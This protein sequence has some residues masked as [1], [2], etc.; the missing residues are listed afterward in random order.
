MHRENMKPRNRRNPPATWPRQLSLEVRRA[1]VL[2]AV[3]ISCSTACLAQEAARS[4]FASIE[5]TV[6]FRKGDG[7]SLLHQARITVES[8]GGSSAASVDVRSPGGVTSTTLGRRDAGLSKHWVDVPDIAQPVQVEFVLRI[9]G[10]EADRRRM[11]WKPRRKWTICW[12]PLAHHDWGYTDS[13]EDVLR[14]YDQIYDSVLEFCD[15][16]RDWPEDSKYRHTVEGSWSI[17]HYITNRPKETIEKLAAYAREG[18]IE[19]PAFYGNEITGM[20]GHEELA[21][22]LYPSFR[23]KRQLGMDIT[24][25]SITDIPGLSWAIPTLL[26]DVNVKY[27]FAGLPTYFQWDNLPVPDFWD[28]SRVLRSHGRPDAFWWEGPD[29]HRVLVYYSG[30]YGC[31]RA[32]SYEEAVE[33]LPKQLDEQ[34]AAGVPFSVVRFGAYG[35][36]DNERPRI[37]DSAI[38]RRWNETWAYPRLVMSTTTM[39]FKALE[40]D[41]EEQG[42]ALRTFRGE[43]PHTD[44]AVGAVSTARETAIN[45]LTHDRLP[46]AEKLAT[47]AAVLAESHVPLARINDAYDD[48]LM[49]DEHTWGMARPAGPVQDWDW[50]DKAHFA[51]RAAGL[52]ETILRQGVERIADR[53]KLDAEGLHLVVFNSLSYPR[54]DVARFPVA[55]WYPIPDYIFQGKFDLVDVE[56]GAKLPFQMVRLDSPQAPVP[57]AAQRYAIGHVTNHHPPSTWRFHHELYDVVF[58][59]TDV[60][61]MGYRTYRV[62][63]RDDAPVPNTSLTLDDTALENRFYRVVLD[64]KTG[65]V[66]SLF[67]KELGKELVDAKAPHKLNQFVARWIKDY[68]QEG[69]ANITIRKGEQGPVYA[70]LRVNGVGA[71]CPELNQEIL[72][73]D[74]VK[75]IDFNNRVLKDSTPHLELY[76]AFPFELDKPRFRF[77]GGNSVIRPFVDQF[78]GSNTNYYSVQH[79]AEASNGGAAVVFA[80]IESHLLEFG[81]LWPCRVSQAHH[82]ITNP[83]F[84]EPFIKPEQ[85]AK[86]YMYSFALMSSF[87]TNFQ[88]TQEGDMLFRYSLTSLAAEPLPS[89]AADSGK[90]IT[91]RPQTFGW[92]VG[93]PLVPFGIGGRRGGTLGAAMGFCTIDQPNVLVT[94]FKP[95]EDSQGYIARLIETE[96]KAVTA[97]VGLPHLTVTKAYR[98]NLGEENAE[99][100]AFG[101]HRVQVSLNPFGIATIRLIVSTGRPGSDVPAGVNPGTSR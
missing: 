16:T 66:A 75:R 95:A 97:G 4:K 82:G 96:G 93:N 29:G 41:I 65:G 22:F 68:R 88:P 59:A 74:Q 73:Y 67:D 70:S 87:R 7:G 72:L 92:A 12:V 42:Q 13:A 33:K 54:S 10:T 14:K 43:L 91:R 9:N 47:M 27:F 53:I 28:A 86:G 15:R 44:Y 79:W 35:C 100:L 81:G 101:P 64:P 46:A 62:L 98:T 6:F 94:T 99:E 37:E 1:A 8:N 49:Y 90:A 32:V 11:E 89:P 69:P 23:I 26:G 21:R 78:P 63:P 83:S 31:N 24:S 2:I 39:F 40:K 5:S 84:A 58:V 34:E 25:A 60:P 76:F 17:Q 19:I 52:T 80:P 20:C 77:E 85:I 45:R 56:S 18:R 61:A 50:S 38:A 51:Y 36:A 71:G 55:G 48:M 57:F 3:A 30:G